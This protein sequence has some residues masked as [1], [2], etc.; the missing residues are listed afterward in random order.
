MEA[1]GPGS[2]SPK[3]GCLVRAFFLVHRQLTSCCPRMMESREILS[4]APPPRRARIPPGPHPLDR[5]SFH[6]TCLQM[7]GHWGFRPQPVNSGRTQTSVP[8]AVAERYVYKRESRPSC[9]YEAARFSG[10]LDVKPDKVKEEILM[11][12]RAQASPLAYLPGPTPSGWKWQI[13][14]KSE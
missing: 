3:M 4:P 1:G 2:G 5:V 13:L 14:E 6:R 11:A 7:P 10:R 12:P 9:T 8:F